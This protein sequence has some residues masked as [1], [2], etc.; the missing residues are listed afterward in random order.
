VLLPRGQLIASLYLLLSRSMDYP[1][2]FQQLSAGRAVGGRIGAPQSVAL[3]P[4]SLNKDCGRGP[5][6]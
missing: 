3:R 1:G 2:G 4:V 5:Q 6:A